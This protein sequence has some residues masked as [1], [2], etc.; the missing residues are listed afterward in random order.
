MHEESVSLRQQPFTMVDYL[1]NQ[2]IALSL[3]EDFKKRLSDDCYDL[4][5]DKKI[6]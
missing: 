6:S 1:K 2:I 5:L 3:E 4:D